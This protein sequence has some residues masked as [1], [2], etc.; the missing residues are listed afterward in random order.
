MIIC[1]I[2]FYFNVREA[3]SPDIP[4]PIMI[5]GSR[6]CS[7]GGADDTFGIEAIFGYFFGSDYCGEDC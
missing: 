2:P 4:A 3:A 5:T 7:V 1:S 6:C